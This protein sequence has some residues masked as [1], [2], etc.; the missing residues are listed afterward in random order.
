[1]NDKQS[2]TPNYYDDEIN[3]RELFELLWK[4]KII[5]IAFTLIVAL[6][7]G[8]FSM[9]ILTPVYDTKLNIIIN[10]PEV[11]Q[12]RYGDYNLPITTNEQYINLFTSN[13]VLINTIRDMGYNSEEITVEGLRGR[14]SIGKVE[15]KANTE[16][17]NFNITVSA[18]NP[19]ESLKLAQ[20]LYDNYIEFV[21][22]IT[23]ERTI[24]YYNNSF[25]VSIKFLENSLKSTREILKKNEELLSQTPKTI[26]Q[27]DA[28]KE[29]A[30]EYPNISDYVV[31]E[32]IINPN[33]IKIESDIVLNKQSINDI[34]NNISQYS[35]YL[36]EIAIEKEAIDKYFL[37]GKATN[38]ETSIIGVVDTYIY[39]PSQ[40]V[41]PTKK[42]SPSNLTNTIIG[43]LLGG[44][45]AVFIV[46]IKD[47]WLKKDKA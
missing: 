43:A 32:N 18:D 44:M 38:L 12:T 17:N 10:M 25:S 9:F 7:T 13:D 26:N 41:A 36:A 46:F 3:L 16:Q 42:T 19:E 33:Y 47:Y 22:T 34:E 8:L 15:A 40:P 4:K 31:L 35:E 20:T 5:I 39:L 1:M 28:I 6:L 2:D 11:Y 21:D 24:N 45:V 37:T 14:V 23:K 27:K 30:D 29:V